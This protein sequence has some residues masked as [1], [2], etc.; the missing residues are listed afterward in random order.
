MTK[1]EIAFAR[2]T[3]ENQKQQDNFMVINVSYDNK[4][5]L[6]HKDGI[7][8]LSAVARAEKFKDDW[9]DSPKVLPLDRNYI[10]S[11]LL[12]PE[13]YHQIKMAQMLNVSL[14]DLQEALQPQT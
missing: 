10:T 14:K 11:S 9:G 13:E 1:E 4:L 8:F 5:I 6:S 3:I 12:S 7:A 2:K